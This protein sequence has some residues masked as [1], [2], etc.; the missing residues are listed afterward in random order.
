[1]SN[2]IAIIEPFKLKWVTTIVEK[3]GVFDKCFINP[4]VDEACTVYL[5]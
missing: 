5:I 2:Y 4:L 1:M 3:S